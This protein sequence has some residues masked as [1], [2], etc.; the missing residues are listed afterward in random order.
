MKITSRDDWEFAGL[1]YDEGI[2][3]TKKDKRPELLRFIE[4][5]KSG[6]VNFIITKSI[7]RWIYKEMGT[8]RILRS[9]VRG[10]HRPGR[11]PRYPLL[12]HENTPA[13]LHRKR[14]IASTLTFLGGCFAATDI[15]L[16][17]SLPEAFLTRAEDLP[18]RNNPCLPCVSGS[19]PR[20]TVHNRR[21]SDYSLL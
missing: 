9:E 3:G 1:Y 7:S 4:D 12:R 20:D 10:K 14:K 6:K 13:L 16:C 5:C 18:K 15:K 8:Y 11:Q 21:A 2:T 17:G 19:L